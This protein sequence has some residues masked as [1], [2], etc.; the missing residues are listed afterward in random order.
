[1]CVC[2]CVCARA[3]TCVC[4]CVCLSVVLVSFFNFISKKDIPVERTVEEVYYKTCVF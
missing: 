2:V 3:R 1:M 4:V